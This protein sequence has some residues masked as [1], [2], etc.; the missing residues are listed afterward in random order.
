M[1]RPHLP[2]P[3]LLK[4]VLEP[5]LEDFQY[6]FER[7]RTLLETETIDFLGPKEQQDLLD[8]VTQ[9]QEEVSS[10]KMM[11]DATGCQA[12]VDMSVLMPWHRL[13][14]ECWQISIR[15]RTQN[16]QALNVRE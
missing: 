9:A 1:S 2:E 15:F 7:S 4:K 6:W 10:A 12:G 11:L 16:S 8:R 3:S 5:L 14:T 13:L